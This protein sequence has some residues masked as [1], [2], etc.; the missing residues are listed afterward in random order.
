MSS[1]SADATILGYFYQFDHTIVRILK[2][3]AST[4]KIVVEGVEDV[5][6]S[7]GGKELFIQC[8]YY[9][10]SEY[11]HS[12]I[13]DAIA[14]MLIHFKGRGC[15]SDG[16]LRYRLYG[17]YKTGQD[18]LDPAFDI[19]F[20]KEKFLTTRK[21]KGDQATV[22]EIFASHAIS[23]HELETFKSSLEI[24]LIAASYEDQQSE[25][26]A[27]LRQLFGGSSAEDAEQFYYPNA[28]N[29][30]QTLA[31]APLVA[32]RTITKA[33]FIARLDRKEAVFSWWLQQKFG[34]AHYAK[35]VRRQ[36]FKFGTRVPAA[37][38]IVVLEFGGEFE[39]KKAL[40][41]IDKIALSLSHKESARTPE[42]QRFCP[43]ILL[44]G[45]TADDL[46]L[47]KQALW[48]RGR[49]IADGYPFLGAEFDPKH[50]SRRPTPADLTKL[51]FLEDVEAI[52]KVLPHH[53]G[54]AID[55]FDFYKTSPIVVT[56]RAWSAVSHNKIKT[57]SV[58]FAGEV[59]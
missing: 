29:I 58:Y 45:V 53:R 54:E 11:N 51:K 2:A 48:N 17:H 26:K 49:P 25:I 40:A 28:I 31:V 59:I 5:D 34:Q 18:K 32:N 39:F 52:T 19:A 6:L 1:R 4:S 41:M 12:L 37:C 24:D 21:G 38:R 43:Y 10:G 8:K 13:K 33:D 55:V 9:S 42:N 46:A 57:E 30:V 47:L 16:S 14:A 15:P 3:A 44:R 23:D 36:H 7:E 56:D 50:L 20:L 27:L 35:S 22:E